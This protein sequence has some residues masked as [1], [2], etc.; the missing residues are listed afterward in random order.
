MKMHDFHLRK[1][2]WN[3]VCKMLV[4][5]FKLQCV[6][7][8]KMSKKMKLPKKPA[9]QE[10]VCLHFKTIF[11]PTNTQHHPLTP[12]PT[13]HPPWFLR[14]LVIKDNIFLVFLWHNDELKILQNRIWQIKLHI[15]PSSVIDHKICLPMYPAAMIMYQKIFLHKASKD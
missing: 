15:I 14:L 4:I 6:K 3:A 9:I 11:L 7:L 1:C 12:T 10:P 5:S 13:P 8:R 2:I